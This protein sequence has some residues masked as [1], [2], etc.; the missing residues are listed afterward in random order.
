MTMTIRPQLQIFTGDN[1]DVQWAVPY[2]SLNLTQE[3]NIGSNLAFNF[4]WQEWQRYCSA[5]GDFDG[6]AILTNSK[7]KAV[8]TKNDIVYFAGYVSSMAFSSTA[9]GD[10]TIR[11]EA[12]DLMSML[13]TRLSSTAF[14][15]APAGQI[16]WQLIQE[17]QAKDFGNLG[18]TQGVI[19]ATKNRDRTLDG[20][21]IKD[22][23]VKM[24]RH[25]LADGFDWEITPE[26]AFNIKNKIG[27]DNQDVVFSGFNS[28]NL[29][30]TLPMVG[31]LANVVT[32]RG[33]SSDEETSPEEVT[34]EDLS[35]ANKWFRHEILVK[36]NGVSEIDT[37]NEKAQAEL[38]AKSNPRDATSISLQHLD[39]AAEYGGVPMTW[40]VLGDNVRVYYPEV[41]IDGLYEVKKRVL[42]V[43]ANLDTVTI[44]LNND[45]PADQYFREQLEL[46]RLA[47]YQQKVN[48]K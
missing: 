22:V 48:Y 10:Y 28:K 17:T 6:I 44:S 47:R 41:K 43:T 9:N 20:D 18:I 1:N 21:N 4:N 11:C 34:L 32:A 25:E 13:S 16:A 40:Y 26:G 36:P 31:K 15:N 35:E 33:S 3:L 30:L 37:L 12:I 24:S 19:E 42:N 46:S 27:E 39:Q 23:I 2:T 45:D 14:S 5:F 8:V 29:Q 7:L 38:D